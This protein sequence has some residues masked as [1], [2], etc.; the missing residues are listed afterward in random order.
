M[1][2]LVN[3]GILI[4][5]LEPSDPRHGAIRSAVRALRSRGDTL[6]TAAQ[7][8]AEFWN[9][10]TRPAAARGGY[11]LSI[12]D[13][14]WR[15]RLIERLF[16]V[17]PDSPAAYQAWR[18][19]LVAHAVRGVQV[20]DVRLVAPMPVNRITHILTLNAGDFARYPGIVP[21]APASLQPPPPP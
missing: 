2:V 21:I 19:L 11:V 7:N 17:L 14:D 13:T 4:Q 1:L 15:P 12:A 5:L 16:H 8:A 9:V 10:C 20:H 6:V 3:S 18:G